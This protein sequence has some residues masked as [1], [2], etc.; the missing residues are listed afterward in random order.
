MSGYDAAKL[1]KV[2]D[3]VREYG[4]GRTTIYEAL[5]LRQLAAIKL[6]RSTRFWRDDVETWLRNQA[7]Y[8]NANTRPTIA[9]TKANH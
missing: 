5:K 7:Q 4:V 9:R 1:L 8:R 2:R 6:G 3:V